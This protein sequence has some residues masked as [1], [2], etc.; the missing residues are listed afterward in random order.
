MGSKFSS[1][2]TTPRSRNM[3]IQLQIPY[4]QPLFQKQRHHDIDVLGKDSA[5]KEEGLE[6][7]L[8]IDESVI[9]KEQWTAQ[10]PLLTVNM[11]ENSRIDNELELL[12]FQES[13][14]S[15]LSSG[16][17]FNLGFIESRQSGPSSNNE[18]LD[19]L[20]FELPPT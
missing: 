9:P 6:P 16:R 7:A 4:I 5:Q 17:G 18:D 8:S 3:V 10:Q 15:S 14:F 19:K 13:Q 20:L 2:T 11:I 1:S 12:Q